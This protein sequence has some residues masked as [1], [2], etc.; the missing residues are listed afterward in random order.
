MVL[1]EGDNLV[2][3]V[4]PDFTNRH[5]ISRNFFLLSDVKLYGTLS[6][7]QEIATIAGFLITISLAAFQIVPLLDGLIYLLAFLVFGRI[8]SVN[9]IRQKFPVD[10]W[11]ILTSALTLATGLVSSGVLRD[12]VTYYHSIFVQLSPFWLMASIYLLTMLLT[13]LMTNAAAAALTF[14]IGYGLAQTMGIDPLPIVMA[15][16]YAASASFITPYGYQTNLMVYNAGGYRF[17]HYALIGAGVSITYSVVVL[18]LIPR[19]FPF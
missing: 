13:E 4:G 14:P 12:F 3:A 7:S 9:D 19:L 11:V 17:R 16:A 2:L 8:L 15:I 1:Q 10:L 6:G 5:N 18:V